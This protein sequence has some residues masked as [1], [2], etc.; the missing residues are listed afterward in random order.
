MALRGM[1]YEDC[2]GGTFVVVDEFP[3]YDVPCLYTEFFIRVKAAT[4]P[5]R[6]TVSMSS[7]WNTC[8][9]I[10]SY[11]MVLGTMLVLAVPMQ[12]KRA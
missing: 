4:S 3:T 9:S 1:L 6:I 11:V 10:R 12:R 2:D 8:F 7:S 5:F